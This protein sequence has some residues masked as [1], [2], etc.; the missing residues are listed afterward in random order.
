MASI[1]IAA[2]S[3]EGAA[4]PSPRARRRSW[5]WLGLLPFFAFLALFLLVPA[6]S[7]FSK[8]LVDADGNF[9]LDALT[10]RL[11]R[12]NRDAFNFSVKLSAL[13]AP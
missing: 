11:H 9:G 8:S 12:Q 3:H 10:R 5:A 4:T 7:V 13:S 2:G 6:I 1:A